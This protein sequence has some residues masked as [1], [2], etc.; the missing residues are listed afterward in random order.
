MVR[1]I[2]NPTIEYVEKRT[3]DPEDKGHSSSMYAIDIFDI[4]IVIV[5]GKPKYTFSNKDVIY[6]PIYVVSKENKIKSQIGVFESVLAN[7]LRLVDEDGDI[8]IDKLGEPLLY[9]RR[10]NGIRKGIGKRIGIRKGKEI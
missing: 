3:I 8:D 10:K 1:S 2:I 4:E 7:T 6:Y 9:T 5:L